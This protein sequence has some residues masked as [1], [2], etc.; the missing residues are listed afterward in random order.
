MNSGLS[1]PPLFEKPIKSKDGPASIRDG[2]QSSKQPNFTFAEDTLPSKSGASNGGDSLMRDSIEKVASKSALK[3][4]T[5]AQSEKK[6]FIKK[7]LTHH[8]VIKNEKLL[9]QAISAPDDLDT[10]SG[11]GIAVIPTGHNSSKNAN[12]NHY[13]T[14]SRDPTQPELQGVSRN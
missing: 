8:V 9:K 13:K 1:K 14:L 7:E 4:V 5:L 2:S 3:T 12:S 6:V 10:P 11:F